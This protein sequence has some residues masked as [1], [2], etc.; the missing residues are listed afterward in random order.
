MQNKYLFIYLQYIIVINHFINPLNF[1]YH[2]KNL[3]IFGGMGFLLL[4]CVTFIAG[5]NQNNLSQLTQANINVLCR[6]ETDGCLSGGPGSSSC[7]ISGDL[8]VGG[9]EGGVSCEVTC[10]SGYYACCSLTGCHRKE[11]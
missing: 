3:S 2:E 8:G 10:Q 1:I 9:V 11:S 7:A 4:C 5:I 6:S